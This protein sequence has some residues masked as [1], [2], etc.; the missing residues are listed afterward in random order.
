MRPGDRRLT[1]P[2]AASRHWRPLAAGTTYVCRLHPDIDRKGEDAGRR[3]ARVTGINRQAPHAYTMTVGAE[4]S[5]GE[6]KA[7][8]GGVVMVS[9]I[10]HMNPST[11]KSL[12]RLLEAYRRAG[13]YFLVPAA[14]AEGGEN[15]RLLAK[16]RFVQT[17][18]IVKGAWEVGEHDPDRLGL[19]LENDPIHSRGD[20][21]LAGLC[22]A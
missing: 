10:Q 13:R 19:S 15:P 4:V 7:S 5:D 20:D 21:R 18:L 17:K 16:H 8:R 22:R 14:L 11:P 12:D 2:R 9:R 6:A 1:E 3:D